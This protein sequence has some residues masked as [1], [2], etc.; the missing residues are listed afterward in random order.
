MAVFRIHK[1][2]GYTVISND[3]FKD[4]S[5]SLKSIGLLCKILSL[6]DNWDYSIKGLSRICK[7]GEDGIKSAIKELEKAGYIN[8]T[9]KRDKKGIIIGMNYDVFECP[10]PL[11]DFPLVGSPLVASP[12]EGKPTQYNKKEPSK[13]LKNKK[14]HNFEQRDYDFDELEKRLI[15]N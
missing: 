15:S 14:K 6:P 10:H 12:S 8:R 1:S 5:L 4:S 3:I 2:S 7:D 9:F 13:Y 11:G